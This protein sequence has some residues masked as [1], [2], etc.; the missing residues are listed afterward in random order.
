MQLSL[1]LYQNPLGETN[2]II[3]QIYTAVRPHE[4][5]LPFDS[6]LVSLYNDVHSTIIMVYRH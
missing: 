3:F 6:H 1:L 5:E 4:M 2:P